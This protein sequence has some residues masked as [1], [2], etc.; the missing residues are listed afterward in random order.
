[1]ANPSQSLPCTILVINVSVHYLALDRHLLNDH[2]MK[3][4][5]NLYHFFK[6]QGYLTPSP[7][8]QQK[9]YRHFHNPPMKYSY[10]LI[11]NVRKMHITVIRIMRLSNRILH[12]RSCSEDYDF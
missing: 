3:R 6:V 7:Q 2:G 5:G 10:A 8:P 12:H 9:F 11:H 4:F 1:M